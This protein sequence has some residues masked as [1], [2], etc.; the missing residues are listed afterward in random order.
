MN[1]QT[2]KSAFE[3]IP[4]AKALYFNEKGEYFTAMHDKCELIEVQKPEE[5]KPK[6]GKEAK[7]KDTEAKEKETKEKDAE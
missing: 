7:E 2:V 4:H 3:A 6:K 5:S 1:D